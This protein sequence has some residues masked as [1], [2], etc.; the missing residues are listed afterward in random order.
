MFLI[1]AYMIS[2]NLCQKSLHLQEAPVAQCVCLRRPQQTAGEAVRPPRHHSEARYQ[3]IVVRPR[4]AAT[5]QQMAGPGKHTL[6][7][8]SPREWRHEDKLDSQLLAHSP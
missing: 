4:E 6:A 7:R 3:Q 8:D 2:P 1:R 5:Q